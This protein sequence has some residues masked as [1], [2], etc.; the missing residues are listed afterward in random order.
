MLVV[1]LELEAK[2]VGLRGNGSLDTY[3]FHFD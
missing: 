2:R 3:G 1:M